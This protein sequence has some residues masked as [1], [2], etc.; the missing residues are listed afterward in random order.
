MIF[1]TI[2]A[3]GDQWS[4]L[5]I[6]KFHPQ[7]MN[8]VYKNRCSPFWESSSSNLQ[9]YD[10]FRYVLGAEKLLC[11]KTCVDFEKSVIISYGI[12]LIIR[13]EFLIN[14]HWK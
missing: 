1:P 13:K 4:R 6:S 11:F 10:H 7:S 5:N 9:G 2:M 3:F 14:S 8:T 12:G